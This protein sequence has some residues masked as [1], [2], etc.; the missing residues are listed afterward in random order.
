MRTIPCYASQARNL[1]LT[2]LGSAESAAPRALAR[3]QKT[4]VLEL[5]DDDLDGSPGVRRFAVTDPL[6][7][8]PPIKRV[9]LRLDLYSAQ[10]EANFLSLN[11]AY[12]LA[13]EIKDVVGETVFGLQ[14]AQRDATGSR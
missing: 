9:L 2:A 5:I 4:K 1:I 7:I 6:S 11:D 12:R 8:A 14:L 10:R 13:I 3:S